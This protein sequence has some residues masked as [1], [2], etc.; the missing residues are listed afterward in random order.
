MASWIT[1]PTTSTGC[2][3][4]SA[5]TNPSKKKATPPTLI[6]DDAV[7][8]IDGKR[9]GKPFYLYL[10]FNAPHTPYQAPKEYL[11]RYQHIPDPTRRT[12]AG[13]VACL[14]DEIGHVVAA[15]DK[16]GLRDNTLILFHSDNGGTRNA[17]FAGEMADLSKVKTALRQRPLSRRQRFPLSKAATRCAACANWPGQHQAPD[18][19]RPHPC[20]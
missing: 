6:G 19:R 2:W 17:M 10:A 7:K 4:G 13:M 15:L 16:K 5:T 8:Y 12:Y 20:R 14:D 9:S 3:T 18:G 11:D 1:S